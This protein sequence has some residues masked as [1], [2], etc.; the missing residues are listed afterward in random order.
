MFIATHE[1]E[2]SDSAWLL[3]RLKGNLKNV[4]SGTTASAFGCFQTLPP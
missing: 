3:L 2:G 1:L 4:E